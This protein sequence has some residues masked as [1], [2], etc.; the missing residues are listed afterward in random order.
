MK[1]YITNILWEYNELTITDEQIYA[2]PTRA[3]V[4]IDEDLVESKEDIETFHTEEVDNLCEYAQCN[5][6][7]ISFLGFNLDVE[8]TITTKEHFQSVKDNMDEWEGYNEM[9]EWD[10]QYNLK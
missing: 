1:A 4:E 10:R 5:G 2:L 8:E 9:A 7:D 3:I 6:F